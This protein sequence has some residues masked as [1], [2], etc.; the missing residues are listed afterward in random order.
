MSAFLPYCRRSFSQL[1]SVSCFGVLLQP[2]LP[3]SGQLL[4]S[5]AHELPLS[6]SATCSD[7]CP[8][9]RRKHIAIKVNDAALIPGFRED[10]TG[11][12][13]H[14]E[15]LVANNELDALQ[16]AVAQPLEETPSSFPYLPSSLRLPPEPHGIR[17]H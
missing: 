1:P 11:C 7:L 10:F 13:E 3:F 15:A 9:Y 14:A 4:Y 5:P 17:L 16:S 8:R 12:F 2:L 6:I